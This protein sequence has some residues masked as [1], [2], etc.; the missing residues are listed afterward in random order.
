MSSH[1][2]RG[3]ARRPPKREEGSKVI[4]VCEGSKTEKNYFEAIRKD[5][6]L[7]TVQIAVYHPNG[8]NPR[9]IVDSAR[10]K[11]Q[12]QI[13][14]K[15]WNGQK[16]TAWAVYDGVE[17]FN[18][19]SADWHEAINIARDHK[20]NLAI[21]NPSFEFYYLLH[22]QDQ[23]G[24]LERDAVKKLLTDKWITDYDKGAV[25]Y[26]V[27]LKKLTG[28]AAAR[29]QKLARYAEENNLELHKCLCAAGVANLVVLLHGLAASSAR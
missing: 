21:T 8:T 18:N 14:D 13:N 22:F 17:H 24:W 27:L 23:T 4:I 6:R 5:L 2:P 12:E 29:A 1:K 7:T 10:Q 16:D 26:P 9:L 19:N 20:I 28:A 3:F 25:Y 11:R 15:T